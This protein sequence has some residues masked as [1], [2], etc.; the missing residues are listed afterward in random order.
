MKKEEWKLY[1][2][3]TLLAEWYGRDFAFTEMSVHTP[4]PVSI[5][6]ELDAFLKRAGKF[7]TA[8]KDKISALWNQI[9]GQKLSCH[10][11]PVK[12]DGSKLFVAVDHPAW[13]MELMRMKNLL[14][15]RIN[16]ILGN[17][18]IQEIVFIN[19]APSVSKS[20]Q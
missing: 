18:T 14:K 13:R 6:Q 15:T 19:Q 12:I 7:E 1:Q 17:N 3:Q 8:G 20:C 16:N 11:S 2:R 10:S 5:E 4:Q 9:V